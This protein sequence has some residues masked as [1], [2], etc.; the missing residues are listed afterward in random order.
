MPGDEQASI[1]DLGVA[2][3]GELRIKLICSKGGSVWSVRFKIE[4]EGFLSRG[5]HCT[6]G[7]RHGQMGVGGRTS[8]GGDGRTSV[9]LGDMGMGSHGEEWRTRQHQP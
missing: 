9:D 8:V 6:E 7:E 2:R 3:S 5:A 4:A 1:L